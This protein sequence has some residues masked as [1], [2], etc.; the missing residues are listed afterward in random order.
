ML[1]DATKTSAVDLDK[2]DDQSMQFETGASPII[3]G[4]GMNMELNDFP[5]NYLT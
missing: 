5:S 4:P 3:S 1:Q 2:I